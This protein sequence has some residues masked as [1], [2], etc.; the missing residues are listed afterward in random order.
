MSVRGLR[1]AVIGLAVLV[2]V[3][4]GVDRGGDLVAEHQAAT[5]LDATFGS[6]PDVDIHGFPF[7]DQWATGRYDA[8]TV[9]GRRVLLDGTR[10]KHV[11]VALRDVRT[12]PFLVNGDLDSVRAGTARIVGSVPF[13]ALPLPHGVTAKRAGDTGDRMRLSGTVTILGQELRISA[14]VTVSLQDGDV[15]LSPRHVKVL[16]PLPSAAATALVSD[17]LSATVQ[18]A[19]LPRGMDITSLSV[20]NTGVRIRAHGTDVTLST[21]Q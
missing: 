1:R 12:D 3:L 13:G 16:G 6:E 11:H 20:T 2:L 5:G 10:A 17:Q 14:V 19:G 8:I 15:E 7:L 4:V 18:P 21:R 9:D